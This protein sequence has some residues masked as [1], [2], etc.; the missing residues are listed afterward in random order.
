MRFLPPN[1]N[2]GGANSVAVGQ[3]NA[4]LSG[5][6]SGPSEQTTTANVSGSKNSSN[7]AGSESGGSLGSN[8]GLGSGGGGGGGGLLK[9]SMDEDGLRELQ[10]NMVVASKIV[11]QHNS[12]GGIAAGEGSVGVGISSSGGGRNGS[13]DE[14]ESAVEEGVEVSLFH[15]CV[16]LR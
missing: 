14:A 2:S 3:D 6:P 8:G 13:A 1:S 12:Q 15:A 11:K 10:D 4:V 9:L 16:L 5:N 7:P